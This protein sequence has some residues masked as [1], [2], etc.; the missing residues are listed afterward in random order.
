VEVTQYTSPYLTGQPGTVI[1]PGG[2]VTIEVITNP[3]SLVQWLPP[4][5]GNSLSKT[6][7]SPGTY[8][9]NVTSCNITT[10]LSINITLSNV[11]ATITSN[12]P[13]VICAGDSLTLTANSGSFSYHW[14]TGSN[15]PYIVVYQPGSYTVTVT[16]VNGCSS[17]SPPFVIGGSLLAPPVFSDITL[18]YGTSENISASANGP[19]QWF[20]G[21]SGGTPFFTGNSYHSPPVF[22]NTTYYLQTYDPICPSI[23]IPLHILLFPGSSVPPIHTNSPL[24]VGDTL[25]IYFTPDT[26]AQYSWTGPDGFSSNDSEIIIPDANINHSGTYTLTISSDSCPNLTVPVN[27]EVYNYPEASFTYSLEPTCEGV[28][29]ELI[30]TSPI[31]TGVEWYFSDGF[32]SN[33]PSL[34]HVFNFND[35]AIIN[36]VVSTNNCRDTVKLSVP[37]VYP[38]LISLPPPNVFTPNGDGQN[39]CF[40]LKT[41]PGY[42]ECY[43]MEIYNRWGRRVFKSE[44]GSTCWNGKDQQD[45][46]DCAPGVY[47]FV[48]T[49]GT[50]SYH[51]SVTLMR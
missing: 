35:T 9:C 49:V 7:S 15:S 14:S 42:S 26:A 41:A 4:L 29:A 47:Y 28:K 50:Q 48:M 22:A 5:S 44:A 43:E 23:R 20:M 13:N 11:T 21:P 31:Y 25:H 30:T 18:C 16:D 6:I 33:S 32:S 45:Q 38:D 37:M 46:K 27:I 2:T 39:D 10:T 34:S 40:R 51:G 17:T 12:G 24:C 1:C 36:L 8:S 19:I 3:G